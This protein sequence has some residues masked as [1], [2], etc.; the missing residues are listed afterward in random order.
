M[1]A[2]HAWQDNVARETRVPHTPQKP[3]FGGTSAP[4]L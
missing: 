3:K 1:P 2:L 4:Q